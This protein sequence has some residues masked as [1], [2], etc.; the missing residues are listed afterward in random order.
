MVKLKLLDILPSEDLKYMYTNSTA[1]EIAEMYGF[2]VSTIRRNLHN[3]GFKKSKFT[4]DMANEIFGEYITG[5]EYD[6]EV[7][8]QMVDTFYKWALDTTNPLKGGDKVVKKIITELRSSSLNEEDDAYQ[9][10]AFDYDNN[11]EPV[12]K[13]RYDSS[14]KKLRIYL[15]GQLYG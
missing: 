2:S 9:L 12:I 8:T 11:K 13:L 14:Q 5:D 4:S 3:L 7:K 6:T 10:S 15:R 1:K